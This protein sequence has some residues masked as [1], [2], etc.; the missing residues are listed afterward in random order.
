MLHEVD[1]QSG[2]WQHLVIIVLARM[3]EQRILD[4]TRLSTETKSNA[5]PARLHTFDP[6]VVLVR[7]RVVSLAR[8]STF[9]QIGVQRVTLH[10]AEHDR[11]VQSMI[12][13][14]PAR[15]HDHV[16]IENVA[17]LLAHHFRVDNVPATIAHRARS[18]VY[19]HSQATLVH[20]W[21]INETQAHLRRRV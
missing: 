18:A 4:H 8:V 13:W 7:A 11:L 14:Q 10:F 21:P 20:T 3:F 6:H 16:G 1:L 15:V 2:R 19:A 5:S 17:E 9:E 12:V